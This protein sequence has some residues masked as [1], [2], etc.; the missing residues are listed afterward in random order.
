VS[1]HH[2]RDQV[3]YDSFARAFGNE[4]QLFTDRS[5]DRA[6]NSEDPSYIMRYIRENHLAGASTLIVLCGLE[7]PDRKFVDWEICAGLNQEMA[8]LGVKLPPLP[9]IDNTARK[10]A[11]L[12]DNIDSEYAPWIWW[13]KLTQSF[14]SLTAAI[15]DAN[16]RRKSLIVNSRPRRVRNG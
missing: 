10:P 9:V 3:Y 2:A 8:L 5:L 6:R 4:L 11:R 14:D 12:Q 1:Y 13:E 16:S 7:T 15:E